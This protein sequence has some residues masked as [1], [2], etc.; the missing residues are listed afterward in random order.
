MHSKF[1]IPTLFAS[2]AGSVLAQAGPQHPAALKR[3]ATYNVSVFGG[4]PSPEEQEQLEK[5]GVD[6]LILGI[7]TVEESQVL[8]VLDSYAPVLERQ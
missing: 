5:L 6:R 2:L 8:A 3:V 7:P 4:P 1:I